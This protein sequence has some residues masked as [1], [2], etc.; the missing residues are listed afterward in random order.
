MDT[1]DLKKDIQIKEWF[2]TN[3]VKEAH[4]KLHRSNNVH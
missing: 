2:A 4:E 3:R 1:K